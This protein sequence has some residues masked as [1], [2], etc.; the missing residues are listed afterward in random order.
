M[1]I[2]EVKFKLEQNNLDCDR[3]QTIEDHTDLDPLELPKEQE[4]D[5]SNETLTYENLD[6][7][8]FEEITIKEEELEI[9]DTELS[10]SNQQ[11]TIGIASMFELNPGPCC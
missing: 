3:L 1:L 2:L 4:N 9:C 5:Y 11:G 10:D 7:L 8:S 6:P